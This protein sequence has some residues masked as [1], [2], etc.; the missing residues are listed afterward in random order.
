[1]FSVEA[2]NMKRQGP[3]LGEIL[4]GARSDDCCNRASAVN[5]CPASPRR[6]RPRK[7][8][9]HFGDQALAMGDH[10][11]NIPLFPQIT[12][13]GQIWVCQDGKA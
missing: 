7:W 3:V 11:R 8:P 4:G 10:L 5:L 9:P 1:M 12:F 13:A 6:R 2:I